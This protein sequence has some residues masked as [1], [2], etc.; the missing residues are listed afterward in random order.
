MFEDLEDDE[1]LD[2]DAF[3][4]EVGARDEAGNRTFIITAIALV[5][6][7]IIGLICL[8]TYLWINSQNGGAS[9]QQTQ[10]AAGFLQQT[11]EA[12]SVQMTIEPQS[13]TATP[14]DTPPPTNTSTPTE[15]VALPTATSEVAE[16]DPAT[17][18]I[19]ALLTQA[20]GQPTQDMTAM[21]T[22]P[23][24]VTGLPQ[25]GFFDDFG[26]NGLIVLAFCALVVIF[27]AR[28]LRVANR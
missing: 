27:L 7:T 21:A 22:I 14:S 11:E 19:A 3:D 28:R 4:D 17:A 5:G 24:V 25:T 13:W 12:Q 6:L 15:V 8:G 20:A 26:I 18:T 23:I 16:E 2:D 1:F 9:T 10:Q